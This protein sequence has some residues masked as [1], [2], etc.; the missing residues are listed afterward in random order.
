MGNG[1]TT[2]LKDPFKVFTIELNGDPDGASPWANSCSMDQTLDN[3][4]IAGAET[5]NP[6]GLGTYEINLSKFNCTS[7]SLD[8]LK[9]SLN[10]VAVKVE[11]GKNPGADNQ[12][13]NYL[14]PMVGF[15]GFGPVPDSPTEGPSAPTESDV[16][17]IYSDTYTAITGINYN[18]GWGQQTTYSEGALSDGNN[19]ITLSNLDFQGID[20]TSNPQD[21]SG[22]TSLHFDYWTT[23]TTT[24]EFFVITGAWPS[25]VE[26]ANNVPITTGSWQSVNIPL[27]AYTDQNVSGY[28]LTDV[29]QLKIVGDGKIFIDNIYFH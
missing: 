4:S 13:D 28:D 7:G 6:Y 18:P 12:T 27:T 9:S 10:E 15:I 14:L 21:V 8:D 25:N 24:L 11:G 26:A 5:S 20:F 3:T 2:E 16:I 23:S 19:V 29:T 17:S 1:A 22:K